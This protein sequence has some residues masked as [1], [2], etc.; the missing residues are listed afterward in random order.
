M[1]LGGGDVNVHVNLRH[2]HIVRFVTGLGGADVNVHVNLRHMHIVRFVIGWGVRMLTFMLTCVTCTSDVTSLGWGGGDV[3][4][5]ANLRH[6]D[7]ATIKVRHTMQSLD[8]IQR[9]C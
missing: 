4:V 1:S 2:M 3:N 5:D 7:V 9:P 8:Q 6:C